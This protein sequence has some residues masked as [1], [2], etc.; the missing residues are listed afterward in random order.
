MKCSKLESK[1]KCLEEDLR[2][3]RAEKPNLFSVRKWL[4]NKNSEKSPN[5]LEQKLIY[6]PKIKILLI[7]ST[8]YEPVRCLQTAVD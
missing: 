3:Y 8:F 5:C 6:I 7:V 1:L 2:Y 4:K